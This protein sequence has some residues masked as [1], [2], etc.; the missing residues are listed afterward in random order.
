[1]D[2]ISSDYGFWIREA[3]KLLPEPSSLGGHL[4]GT[5][6][7]LIGHDGLVSPA[8][9]E[10]YEQ[11]KR[12]AC[13]WLHKKQGNDNWSPFREAEALFDNRT[14][15]R[16]ILGDDIRLESAFGIAAIATLGEAGL[17]YQ[18]FANEPPEPPEFMSRGELEAFHGI[19]K[20]SALVVLGRRLRDLP[21]EDSAETNLEEARRVLNRS[22][23]EKRNEKYRHLHTEFARYLARNS[24]KS[25]RNA[26]KVFYEA[27][28]T[29]LQHYNSVEHAV[30]NL[31][32]P[33]YGKKKTK[34]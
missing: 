8:E 22:A 5:A 18:A 32:A 3:S 19:A 7:E 34:N 29:E 30:R 2:G 15:I 26:A 12:I 14:I 27:L 21:T 1:M 25:I 13:P 9:W 6:T 24:V 11:A 20:A 31:S 28:P 23:A 33:Y 4:L 10:F 16:E 17:L